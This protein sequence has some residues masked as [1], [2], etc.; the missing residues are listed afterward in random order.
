MKQI[1]KYRENNAQK[2]AMDTIRR[3]LMQMNQCNRNTEME[4]Q[5]LEYQCFLATQALEIN[6]LAG[7]LKL[8]KEIMGMIE[9][10]YKE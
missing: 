7:H 2:M 9:S 4:R 3:V 8:L 5:I 6:K 1:M 10:T